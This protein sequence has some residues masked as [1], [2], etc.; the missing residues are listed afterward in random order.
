MQMK[1]SDEVLGSR[2][3]TNSTVVSI[4]DWSL[5]LSPLLNLLVAAWKLSP[6]LL[7]EP[8]KRHSLRMRKVKRSFS[9]PLSLACKANDKASS[10]PVLLLS[11]ESENAT[12][13]AMQSQEEK[14]K[15]KATRRP[16]KRYWSS[17]RRVLFL[18]C[19]SQFKKLI[20]SSFLILYS[21]C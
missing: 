13:K 20:P 1:A 10:L 4:V 9:F 11:G 19:P 3:Q 12:D 6:F 21:L 17:Y 2:P 8:T 18:A 7:Q 16:T 14:N 15:E 5:S